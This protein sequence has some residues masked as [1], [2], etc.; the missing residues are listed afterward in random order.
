MDDYEIPVDR[1]VT[2]GLYQW[3]D[4]QDLVAQARQSGHLKN[5]GELFIG[6]V[7]LSPGLPKSYFRELPDMLCARHYL[8]QFDKPTATWSV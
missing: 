1:W 5:D 4:Y 8:V 3:T 7:Y 6:A 2:I